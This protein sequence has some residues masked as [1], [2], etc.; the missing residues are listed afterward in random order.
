[1]ADNTNSLIESGRDV[2][3]QPQHSSTLAE[4][5]RAGNLDRLATR[6]EEGSSGGNSQSEYDEDDD[7]TDEDYYGYQISDAQAEWEESLRQLEQLLT[8]VLI[9]VVGKFFGRR[10]AY[11]GKLDENQNVRLLSAN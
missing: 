11:F 8:F 4:L 3:S 6:I 1:M 5:Y 2:S 9:P 7:Y 10:F